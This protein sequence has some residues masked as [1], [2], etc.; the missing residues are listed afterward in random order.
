[1]TIFKADIQDEL[2]AGFTM[3][4]ARFLTTPRLPAALH[5]HTP[6]LHDLDPPPFLFGKD[7]GGEIK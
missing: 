4:H 5:M 7:K 3:A 1:M 2:L 6:F